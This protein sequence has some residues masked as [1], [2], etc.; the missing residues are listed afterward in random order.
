MEQDKSSDTKGSF[1]KDV[2]NFHDNAEGSISLK[3][4]LEQVGRCGERVAGITGKRI[5]TG[6][7]GLI[8]EDSTHEDITTIYDDLITAR[9]RGG[10]YGS[11]AYKW[12]YAETDEGGIT[13]W[14]WAGGIRPR[15]PHMCGCAARLALLNLLLRSRPCTRPY[16]AFLAYHR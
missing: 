14:L 15:C 6:T 9:S 4:F 2:H 11:D 16:S 12:L 10:T 8:N 7:Q 5:Y 13:P 1:E 3:E